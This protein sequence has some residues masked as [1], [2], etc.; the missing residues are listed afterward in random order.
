[1]G[2]SSV[3]VM[4]VLESVRGSVCR[5]LAELGA[6]QW[7]LGCSECQGSAN[8]Q[9][10]G[11]CKSVSHS[12]WTMFIWQGLQLLEEEGCVVFA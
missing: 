7:V 9:V 10:F 5:L 12:M 8:Q 3:L 1:M 4:M 6:Q 2:S 11:W